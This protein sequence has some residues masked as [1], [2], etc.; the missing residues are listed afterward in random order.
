[1]TRSS[2]SIKF[3]TS[4]SALGT[5]DIYVLGSARKFW[6]EHAANGKF[7][8]VPPP[9]QQVDGNAVA[10][11][12]LDANTV[13]VLGLDRNLWLERSVNGEFGQVP[14]PREHV[15]GNVSAFQT[16]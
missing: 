11:Q 4:F 2:L 13:C 10:F 12:A 1:M 8:V 7:G 16:R 14:P 9:R 15:D 5:S 6:L 3:A